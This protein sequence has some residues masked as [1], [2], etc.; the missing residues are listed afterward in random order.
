MPDEFQLKGKVTV[1]TSE[2]DKLPDK[3]SAAAKKAQLAAVRA[4]LAALQNTPNPVP[5]IGAL[6]G[7]GATVTGSPNTAAGRRAAIAAAVAAAGNVQVAAAAAGAAAGVR[8]AGRNRAIA[9]AGGR[10]PRAPAGRRPAAFGGQ[11]GSPLAGFF[12]GFLQQATAGTGLGVPFLS[13]SPTF[14]GASVAASAFVLSIKKALQAVEE[15]A[16]GIVQLR[17][18]AGGTLTQ[19]SQLVA[20][21]RQFGVGADTVAQGVEAIRKR[22]VENDPVFKRLGIDVR[23]TAGNVKDAG[24][25]FMET[26]RAISQI[27]SP[28]LQA[29]AAYD[30]YGDS[31]QKLMPFLRQTPEVIAANA[32]AIDKQ[33]K[34]GEAA[35]AQQEA[36]T[37]H[38][39]TVKNAVGGLF[40]F[41]G[42]KLEQGGNALADNF[43]KQAKL[44]AA[45]QKGIEAQNKARAEGLSL[46]DQITARVAAR[47]AFL[48]TQT[49]VLPKIGDIAASGLDASV[50]GLKRSLLPR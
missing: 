44:F 39:N 13:L 30:A 7:G 38:G 17:A 46:E 22:A 40:E 24:T 43:E 21:A 19:T 14:I 23:D 25:L 34:A 4:Q 8:A 42:T 41:I 29:A 47:D 37:R 45:E 48:N 11:S 18:I 5:P 12:R 33:T 3:T 28:T 6:V 2:L 15:L 27:K 10:P 1:D 9:G 16:N 31:F 26:Q 49:A 36:A 20:T 35:V 50:T 32:D